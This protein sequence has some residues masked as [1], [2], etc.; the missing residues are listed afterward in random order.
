MM[1][2]IS[3]KLEKV[4]IFIPKATILAPANIPKIIY[5]SFL[6]NFRMPFYFLRP[7]GGQHKGMFKHPLHKQEVE[8]LEC[9]QGTG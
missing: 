6:T 5:V 1:L 8:N 4:T 3:E 7:V 9:Q 2:V